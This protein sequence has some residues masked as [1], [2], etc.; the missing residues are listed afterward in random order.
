MAKLTWDVTGERRYETGVDRAVLYPMA[1]G[2]YVAGVAWSG[3]TGVTESPS[4]AEANP[5]YAD[6]I[7]YLNIMSAEEFG[8]TI[9]A[10]MYPDE[11]AECNGEGA[12]ATGVNIGQQSRKAFGMCYRTI[13][14]NDTDG[15]DFGYKLHLIYGAQVSPSERGYQTVS[16]S[17][18]PTTMSWEF[19]TT[20]VMVDGFKATSYLTIDSTK[21]DEEKLAA[22]EA[23]LY[24]TDDEEPTLLLPNELKAMLAA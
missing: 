13:I 4:G 7:K 11:F 22:I 18:E 15:N 20:P 16:D 24:G 17:P 12:L 3:L 21:I 1:A 19:T 6:N 8:G 5:F 2:K 9:E 14:G 10:Y 23:K